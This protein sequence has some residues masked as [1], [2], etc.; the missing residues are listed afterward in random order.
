MGKWR[1]AGNIILL[2]AVLIPKFMH[3]S[4][5]CSLTIELQ[6]PELAISIHHTSELDTR[7]RSLHRRH[8]R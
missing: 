6:K 5:T 8:A 1:R 7:W 4:I 3:G 2:G